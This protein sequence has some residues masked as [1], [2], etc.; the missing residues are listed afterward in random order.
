MLKRYLQQE[1]IAALQQKSSY[2]ATVVLRSLAKKELDCKSKAS[3]WQVSDTER[4]QHGYSNLRF[5]DGLGR[6]LQ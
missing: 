4:V 5:N 6:A 1:Q 2:Q 3:Q